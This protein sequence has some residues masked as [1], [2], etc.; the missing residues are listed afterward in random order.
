V[1]TPTPTCTSPVTLHYTHPPARTDPYIYT[2]IQSSVKHPISIPALVPSKPADPGPLLP[3]HFTG[4]RPTTSSCNTTLA[5]VQPLV[6]WRATI[7]TTTCKPPQY[8]CSSAW[9]LSNNY[10]A[11]AEATSQAPP[12]KQY[13]AFPPKENDRRPLF[14]SLARALSL[15]LFLTR[16]ASMSSQSTSNPS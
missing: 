8:N 6:S 7:A 3:Q 9:R 1:S 12:G 11:M 16:P 13:K 2:Y 14:L 5:F 15:F 10:A 4:Q